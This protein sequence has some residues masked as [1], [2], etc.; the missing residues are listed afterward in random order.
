MDPYIWSS[1]QILKQTGLKLYMSKTENLKPET[2]PPYRPSSE[3]ELSRSLMDS[4][5][6]VSGGKKAV[7]PASLITQETQSQQVDLRR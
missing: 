3:L 7:K 2:C 1:P 6:Q 5:Q 4:E